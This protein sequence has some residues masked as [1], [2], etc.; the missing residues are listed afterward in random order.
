MGRRATTRL[1]EHCAQFD[2]TVDVVRRHEYI[3][4]RQHRA[5]A[6]RPRLE[7]TIAQQRIEPEQAMTGLVQPV[8]L[9]AQFASEV[10][11]QPIRD[12][13]NHCIL[14]QH[15]TRPALI[16]IMDRSTDPRAARPIGYR[17][18]NGIHGHIDIAM[19]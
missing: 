14:S 10:T 3:H 7:I 19:T 5:D 15:A 12:E 16:E 9:F 1:I 4:M 2:E 6:S 18:G 8:H 13:Q 17:V 11:I